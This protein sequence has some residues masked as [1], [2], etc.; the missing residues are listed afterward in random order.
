MTEAVTKLDFAYLQAKQTLKLE[1]EEAAAAIVANTN[2]EV[3]I[4]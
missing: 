1:A 2:A 3:S 4:K